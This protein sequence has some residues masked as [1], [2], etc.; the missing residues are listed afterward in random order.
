MEVDVQLARRF[1]R[2]RAVSGRMRVAIAVWVVASHHM[3]N[4]YNAGQESED[5]GQLQGF[6]RARGRQQKRTI[7]VTAT[8]GTH[9]AGA[10]SRQSIM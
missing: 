7:R 6:F 3:K 9:P 1:R 10:R 2:F 8:C 5:P 4:A